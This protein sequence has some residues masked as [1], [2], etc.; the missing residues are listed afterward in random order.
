MG[1]IMSDEAEETGRQ[2]PVVAGATSNIK[3]AAAALTLPW[4]GVCLAAAT[5]PEVF[6]WVRI[7]AST[8]GLLGAVIAYRWTRSNVTITQNAVTV[9]GIIRRRRFMFTELQ[10]VELVTAGAFGWRTP[11]LTLKAGGHV[12][13]GFICD[14]FLQMRRSARGRAVDLVQVLQERLR[15]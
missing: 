7:T 3:I 8:L 14:S 13:I 2:P 4:I 12:T 6:S 5:A 15:T 11:R 10:D 9:S 1:V